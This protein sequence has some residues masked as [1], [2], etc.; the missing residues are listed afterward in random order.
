MKSSSSP[1]TLDKSILTLTFGDVVKGGLVVT[2]GTVGG[3]VVVV[4]GVVDERRGSQ[5]LKNQNDGSVIG[6]DSGPTTHHLIT[7]TLHL[8]FTHTTELRSTRHT[9]R[10]TDSDH[11]HHCDRH[12]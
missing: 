9:C 8:P 5:M 11:H 1:V 4:A 12:Q 7:L 2:V 3:V 10:E 6:A